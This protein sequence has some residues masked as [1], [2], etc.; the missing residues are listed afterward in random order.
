MQVSFIAI[1][2]RLRDF[3]RHIAGTV[4]FAIQD[5]SEIVFSKFKIVFVIRTQSA[6]SL[7]KL[8]IDLCHF[9]RLNKP[10][11]YNRF[12]KV[13]SSYTYTFICFSSLFGEPCKK[14]FSL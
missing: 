4:L 1:F 6:K 13:N 7:V 14:L 11:I 10:T 12:H 8:K 9:H 5:V 3:C 2:M